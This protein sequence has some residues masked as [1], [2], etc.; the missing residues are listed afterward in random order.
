MNYEEICNFETLFKA[1]KAA[2]R[3]KRGKAQ[4]ARY[5]QHVVENT[6]ALAELLKSGNY[7]PGSFQTFFVYEPKKR[8]VQAPAFVDKVVQHALV[9]NGFYDDIAR[10]FVYENAASQIDKGTF[11]ALD[12]LKKNLLDYYRKN[13]T[14]EGWVLKCDIRHFFASIDHDI[15]KIKLRSVVKDANVLALLFRYID[16]SKEGLPLGYQTS[17]LFA[18]LY[19]DR[20][21]HYVKEILRVKHYGRYMDDFYII[22]RDKEQA[23]EFRDK[24]IDYLGHLRLELNEK[25]KIFPLRNGLDFL[26]FHTYLTETGKVVRKLRRA[27]IKRL[28]GKIKYWRKAYPEGKVTKEEILRKFDAWDA[29]A[30]HGDTF[31]LRRKYAEQIGEILFQEVYIRKAVKTSGKNVRR[32]KVGKTEQERIDEWYLNEIIKPQEVD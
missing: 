26:G 9:D 30:A 15:L 3:S 21:D 28:K 25:T 29:H 12:G 11:F 23:K 19:L 32:I 20:F 10:S 5:E 22:C 6:L 27:S 24:I 14:T 16:A 2:R 31:S 4:E 1:F 17:Q 13:G 7:K 18:L 8:L